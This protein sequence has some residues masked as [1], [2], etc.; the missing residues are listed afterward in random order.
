MVLKGMWERCGVPEVSKV[1]HRSRG[2][3]TCTF[4]F[5]EKPEH[6]ARAPKQRT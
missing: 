6:A 5:L 3:Q 2:V 4:F 1:M